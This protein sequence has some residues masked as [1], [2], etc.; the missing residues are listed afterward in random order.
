VYDYTLQ[1]F[2][3]LPAFEQQ[4]LLA[5]ILSGTSLASIYVT[6]LSVLWMTPFSGDTNQEPEYSMRPIRE[7]M[8]NYLPAIS[9]ALAT[10]LLEAA[11]W[12]TKLGR[13]RLATYSFCLKSCTSREVYG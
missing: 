2:S 9:M 12:A 4:W 8:S 6:D 10:Y 13:D 5:H 3:A 1:H 7:V 11:I